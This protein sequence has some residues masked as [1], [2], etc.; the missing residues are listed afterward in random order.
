[1]RLA[2]ALALIGCGGERAASAPQPGVAPALDALIAGVASGSLQALG[3]AVAEP[4]GVPLHH[5]KPIWKLAGAKGHLVGVDAGGGLVVWDAKTARP[6]ATFQSA[7]TRP[8]RIAIAPDGGRLALCANKACELIDLDTGAGQMIDAGAPVV[9]CAWFPDGR[10]G[11]AAA[12]LALYEAK[13]LLPIEPLSPSEPPASL[14]IGA[15]G[16]VAIA[17]TLGSVW[18]WSGKGGEPPRLVA[19]HLDPTLPIAIGPR[20]H[21]AY[22]IDHEGHIHAWLLDRLEAPGH[23]QF[24][25]DATDVLRDWVV[26]PR[27][28]VD[29]DTDRPVLA[30]AD[31]AVAWGDQLATLRGDTATLW[32]FGGL[33]IG[34]SNAIVAIVPRGDRLL[35]AARDGLAIV[36]KNG[37]IVRTFARAD[38]PLVG[39]GF[40]TDTRIATG[41]AEGH[42]HL[43]DIDS[44]TEL[45]HFDY[46][47][48]LACLVVQPD[49]RV[50][51]ATT[52]GQLETRDAVLTHPQPLATSPCRPG[53][54]IA[55]AGDWRITGDASGAL[56]LHPLTSQ[57]A[58]ARACGIL[59]RFERSDE[60][61]AACR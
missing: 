27:G 45:A 57:A 51:V 29:P 47:A 21:Y 8:E 44:G 19:A 16:F 33:L 3:A 61:G 17:T 36:W 11:I 56:R 13:T 22:Q 54:P 6:V 42:V 35:T 39:T 4:I 26:T 46:E 25:A 50:A 55:T 28:L 53:T 5:A 60:L 9:G 2:L 49:G 15:S 30:I 40:V 12:N 24:P 23:G 20:E 31:T 7:I 14:A 52:A 48:D 1:M 43:Y 32:T 41:D 38:A 34:H 37:A 59:R 18:Y 10:L 58:I